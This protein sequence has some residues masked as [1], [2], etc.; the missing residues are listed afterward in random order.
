M[1]LK[2]EGGR[3][4]VISLGGQSLWKRASHRWDLLKVV[5]LSLNRF[6]FS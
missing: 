6:V 2:G 5:F 1:Q 4:L 3:A